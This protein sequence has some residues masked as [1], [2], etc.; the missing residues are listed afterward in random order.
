MIKLRKYTPYA[1][2][3]LFMFMMGGEF[4]MDYL[5]E[6]NSE[7]THRHECCSCPSHQEEC[8][9][10]NEFASHKC[11]SNEVNLDLDEAI[12]TGE[13]SSIQRVEKQIIQKLLIIDSEPFAEL[14]SELYTPQDILYSSQWCIQSSALRAPPVLV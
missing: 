1:L 7:H 9:N 3:L 5:C 12:V 11:H 10:H 4:I 13:N 6:C 14:L 8:R 2:L